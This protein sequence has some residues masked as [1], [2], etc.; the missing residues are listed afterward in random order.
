MTPT[1]PRLARALAVIALASAPAIA[2]PPDPPP[3]RQ[4]TPDDPYLPGTGGSA[5]V[6]GGGVVFGDFVSIQVNV[7]ALGNNI[8]NDAANESS[9]A[10]DPTAPNRMVIGWRQ[11]DNVA[12]NFRQAGWGWSHDGGR[13]WT[14]PGVIQPGLFRSDPVLGADADGTIYYC[15]LSGGDFSVE[16]FKSFD[17][18]LS[19]GPELPAFGGDKQWFTI[20]RTGGP[21]H[22]NIYEC[23]SVNAGCCGPDA[24]T[25]STNGAASFSTPVEIS[26]TPI[27]GTNT[28]GP[29][30]A[31]YVVGATPGNLSEFWVAKST[32]VQ[33][34]GIP[35]FDFVSAV[36]M[37]GAM[38][39]GAACNPGGLAGQAQVAVDASGGPTHG[40]VYVLCSVDPPGVDPLDVHLVRSE[41]GGLNWSPPVRVNDDD[42]GTIA[43]QWFGT[44]SVA[45][46]GRID[47]VWNDTRGTATENLS[48]TFYASSSN[49]GVSFSP[50][51]PMTPIWNSHVGWPNQ[52][53]IGDYY[54][55]IS[56]DVGASLAYAT[57]F[58]GEQDV[59]SLRIGDYD[60][61]ANGVPDPD[62][63][64]GPSADCNANGIPDECEIAAGTVPDRNK[65]GIP[66]GCSACPWD[67]DGSGT[68]GI[69]DLLDLLAGWGDPWNINDLL[70]LLAAWGPC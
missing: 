21:G 29:D 49:G 24:F 6:A 32:T 39:F 14:F 41:D 38:D 30:G 58:N 66:D 1:P 18:G 52:N 22:G 43:W 64:A 60:C 35:S 7:N 20:D 2:A 50:N 15:S 42:V 46:N 12:S 53:K 54:G 51:V 61:N 59:W 48:R 13:T 33:N 16:F 40:N 57:T 56:D 10:I 55:M 65:D 63:I 9:I 27:W 37:G 3:L 11:F 4:E 36:N 26:N 62:D 47:V 67:L 70:D 19:W 17:A 69:N 34:P 23:W 45:P 28:V 31:V 68:V 44:M 25:R 5:T 8:V